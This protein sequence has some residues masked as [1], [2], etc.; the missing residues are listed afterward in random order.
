[1]SSPTST[2]SKFWNIRNVLALLFTAML[3]GLIAVHVFVST[4]EIPEI[5]VGA[6]IVQITL[7]VQFYFRRSEPA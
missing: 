4:V 2:L 3:G 5:I 1:M 6:A 7:I